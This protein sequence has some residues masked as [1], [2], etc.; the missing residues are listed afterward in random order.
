MKGGQEMTFPSHPYDSYYNILKPALV[1]KVEEFNLLQYGK[2][3]ERD[4]WNYLTMKKWKKPK[5]GIRMYELVSDVLS[6]NATDYMNFI[7]VEAYK[8]SNLLSDLD[9]EELQSLLEPHDT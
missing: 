1:S 2:I 5:E 8:S 3:N 9:S 7:T 6:V 4:I